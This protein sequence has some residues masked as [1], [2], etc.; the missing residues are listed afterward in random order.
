MGKCKHESGVLTMYILHSKNI[1]NWH[2]FKTFH[3][4]YGN[5]VIACLILDRNYINSPT[6][7]QSSQMQ[8]KLREHIKIS[9]RT[10][11][12]KFLLVIT[13]LKQRMGDSSL[14][15]SKGVHFTACMGTIEHSMSFQSLPN[16]NYMLITRLICIQ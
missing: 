4:Y 5:M 1:T 3:P 13:I 14:F 2:K 16:I 9:P 7:S 12:I 15:G 8:T 6:T 11:C 10:I